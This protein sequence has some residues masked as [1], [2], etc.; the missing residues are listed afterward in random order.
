M[1][2]S[3]TKKLV[4]TTMLLLTFSN[5]SS[6]QK[7]EPKERVTEPDH[8]ITS[9]LKGRDYQLYI[10]FPKGYSTK[11]T[12]SYPVLYALDG[13]LF[14]HSVRA[15][16]DILYLI[17]NEIEDVIIVVIGS[18]GLDFQSSFFNRTYDYT[19]SVDTASVRNLEKQFGFPE[20]ALKSGGADKFLECIKTEIAPFVDKHYKTNNDRGIVGNSLGGLF[21]AY[22]LINSDG[23]F[24]RFGINSPSF[25]WDKRKLLNQ[26][27]LQFTNNNSWDIP[28]TK[29]FVSVGEKEGSS[30]LPTMQKF[31]SLL[32][33]AGY[34]NIDLKW[35]IFDGETHMSVVPASVCRAITTLYGK[36]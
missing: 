24:T 23:Y 31:N 26:A 30:M 22:C 18:E 25:W 3:K 28:P 16:T 9:E 32:E 12:I 11:D 36:K 7:L 33:D 5:I 19:T 4:L 21:A 8:V 29:V 17:G 15:A 2:T 6:G 34:E 14:F 35:Q 13:S 1:K 27:D 10:S 20:G